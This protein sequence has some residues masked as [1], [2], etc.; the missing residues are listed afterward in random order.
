MYNTYVSIIKFAPVIFIS[1]ILNLRWNYIDVFIIFTKIT[2]YN[3]WR[4]VLYGQ[5]VSI[6]T[7]LII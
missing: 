4:S 6:Y 1:N 7:G 5:F 2:T 3:T